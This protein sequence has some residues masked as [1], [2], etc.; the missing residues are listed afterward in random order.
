MKS[1]AE[2][3]SLHHRKLLSAKLVFIETKRVLEQGVSDSVKRK[4]LASSI[5][6]LFKGL[7]RQIHKDTVSLDDE[8]LPLD[9]FL[10]EAFREFQ[11]VIIQ[12]LREDQSTQK[13]TLTV[14]QEKIDTICC[15]RCSH[16]SDYVCKDGKHDNALVHQTGRCISSVKNIFDATCKVA[17]SYYKQYGDKE[18]TRFLPS[19]DLSTE[20]VAE[21]PH[22]FPV[23]YHIGGR[24]LYIDDK[25]HHSRITLYLNT[26][27]FDPESFAAIAYVFFHEIISHAFYEVAFKTGKRRYSLPRDCFA[28]GW[29]DWVAYKVM[30]QVFDERRRKYQPYVAA[31]SSLQEHW[32]HAQLFHLARINE[33]AYDSDS[34]L[35]DNA[36]ERHIGKQ[37][38]SSLF[39]LL[40]KSKLLPRINPLKVFLGL[41]FDLNML[42]TITAEQRDLFIRA[43]NFLEEHGNFEDDSNPVHYTIAQI[44]KRYLLD[45]SKKRLYN[46]LDEIERFS[47]SES[48]ID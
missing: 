38:A 31:I 45:D 47:I 23:D 35:Q 40:L 2:H 21:K 36:R 1:E 4:A 26:K 17:R 9:K 29:M 10:K 43:M 7:A 12:E 32:E 41:S 28:E 16:V 33:M 14:I 3:L 25:N 46:L 42:A 11:P 18:L 48:G 20:Y 13:R 37:A 22:E 8:G 39:S 6:V 24:T 44:V 5:D 19:V 34:E 30:G 15:K 27:K